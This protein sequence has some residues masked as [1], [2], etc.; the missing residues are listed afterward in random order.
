[1]LASA[2][3]RR[4][5]REEEEEEESMWC[6]AHRNDGPQ[7]KRCIHGSEMLDMAVKADRHRGGAAEFKAAEDRF[8]GRELP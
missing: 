7:E 2:L 6:M 5:E 8:A 1:M 3:S 4:E